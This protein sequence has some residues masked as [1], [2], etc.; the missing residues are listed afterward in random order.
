MEKDKKRSESGDAGGPPEPIGDYRG[1]LPD[2]FG[3][4]FQ[5]GTI[6]CCKDTPMLGLYS[7]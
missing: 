7:G 4:A 5:G 2:T 3:I 6:D 1:E